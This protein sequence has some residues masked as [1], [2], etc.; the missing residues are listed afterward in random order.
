MMFAA[1]KLGGA[2]RFSSMKLK[3]EFAALLAGTLLLIAALFGNLFA[4]IGK[5]F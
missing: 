5:L 2:A 3:L 4:E 1:P